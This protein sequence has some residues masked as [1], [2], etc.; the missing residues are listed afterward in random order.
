MD[1]TQPSILARDDRFDDDGFIARAQLFSRILAI[2]VGL[3]GTVVLTGWIFDAETFK[4]VFAGSTMTVNEALSLVLAGVSLWTL[5]AFRSAPTIG[6]IGKVSAAFVGL[7][8]ALTLSEHIAGW[9]LGID[10][11]LVADEA[12]AI[13]NG[14]AGRMGPP[15]SACFTLAGIALLLLHTHRRVAVAQLLT[16]L[17]AFWSLLA[18]IGFAYRAEMLSAIGSLTGIALHTAAALFTLSIGLFAART[19]HGIVS[20]ISGDGAG[21]VM[22]RPLLIFAIIVPFLLGLLR[23]QAQWAGLYD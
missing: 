20:I 18:I 8:G 17:V 22:A 10:Q 11:L 16:M 7:L 14:N 5:T 2:L 23:L 1:A 3:V 21:S 15:A 13:A 6:R 4:S 12:D 19:E 9:N